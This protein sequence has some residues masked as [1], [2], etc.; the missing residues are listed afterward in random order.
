MNQPRLHARPVRLREANEM[1]RR[2]HRHHN[3]VAGCLFCIAVE[4]DESTWRGV[5]IVGR[6]VSRGNDDGWTAE[7]L[8]VATDGCDNAC[9]FL[10][11]A[12]WRAVRAM[13]YLRLGTYTLTSEPGT[14]LRAAGWQLLYT[15]KARSWDCPGRPRDP[16]DPQERFYWEVA[17]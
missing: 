1:V 9:S 16:G 7:V 2:I 17:S 14:S 12:C 3:P 4:D 11:A 5:A 15:V 8:R 13:G 10:Y 6:P